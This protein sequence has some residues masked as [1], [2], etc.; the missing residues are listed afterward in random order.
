MPIHGL[1][2]TPRLPQIGDLR[3]GAPKTGNRP[4]Q[5]LEHFRFT[6]EEPG[7]EARFRD[8]YGEAPR[9]LSI[10]LPYATADE[11]F[12]AW[13]EEYR[14]GGLVRRCDGSACVLWQTPEGEYSDAEKPC[15][16][17]ESPPCQCKETGRLHIILPALE[18]MGTVCVHT[19]SVNDI[20]TLHGALSA[21]ERIAQASGRDLRGVPFVLKRRPRKISTPGQ[22]GQRVRREKW[23]L[24]IEPE[25]QWVSLQLQEAKQRALAYREMGEA[26]RLTDGTPAESPQEVVVETARQLTGPDATALKE[27]QTAA[28][29]YGFSPEDRDLRLAFTSCLVGYDIGSYRDLSGDEADYAITCMEHVRRRITSGE[30]RVAFAAW[31]ARNDADVQGTQELDDLIAH[32]MA[33]GVGVGQ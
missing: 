27:V 2:D 7:L 21:L 6:S 28:S 19:T 4:G 15:A 13:L 5:D 18:R 9:E 33:D 1:T 32:F 17:D 14:A 11:N 16:Q 25:P 12:D 22:N 3:K 30:T 29:D 23:L 8:E 20:K 26:P 31:C 10:R 24:T